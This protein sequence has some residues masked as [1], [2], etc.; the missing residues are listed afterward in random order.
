MLSFMTFFSSLR[1][2]AT[3]FYSY[4]AFSNTGSHFLSSYPRSATNFSTS[5][6][7]GILGA[8]PF[9]LT[10][11]ALAA[12]AVPGLAFLFCP[13]VWPLPETVAGHLARARRI[14]AIENNQ[15]GQFADLLQRETGARIAT[16]ILKYN[17]MP[18]A[19]E[20]LVARIGGEL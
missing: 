8:A 20:E 1:L 15:V 3:I 14:I 19:V 5:S 4:S 10:A 6:Y 12:L 18:F 16:R 11:M 2:A 7:S 9:R 13:Q 17:G